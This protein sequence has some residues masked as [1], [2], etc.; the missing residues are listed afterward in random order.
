MGENEMCSEMEILDGINDE[1]QESLQRYLMH[2]AISSSQKSG[3]GPC[4]TKP[5]GYEESQ[6]IAQDK[7]PKQMPFIPPLN[8]NG[9]A[10]ITLAVAG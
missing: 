7:S 3:S 6:I 4:H 5:G 9:L 8:F 1:D 2:G 10:N